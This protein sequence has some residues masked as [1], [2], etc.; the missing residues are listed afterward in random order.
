M[1]ASYVHIN[2]PL[3]WI[4]KLRFQ[5][6]PFLGSIKPTTYQSPAVSWRLEQSQECSEML[7]DDSELIQLR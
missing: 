3:H 5:C 2:S 1:Y 7:S 6:K 4:H